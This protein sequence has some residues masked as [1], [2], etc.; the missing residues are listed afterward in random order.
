ML[1]RVRLDVVL[2]A[3]LAHGHG[4]VGA[5]ESG[6]VGELDSRI[7][8]GRVREW[9]SARLGEKDNASVRDWGSATS[10]RK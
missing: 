1:S 2:A 4:G 5:C 9:E 3:S 8:G 6:R 10:A 7:V